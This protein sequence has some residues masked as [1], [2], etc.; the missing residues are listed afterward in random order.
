[1]PTIAEAESQIRATDAPVLFLDTCIY[2]DVIRA[3]DR[4][5]NGFVRSGRD[6]LDLLTADPPRCTL[7]ATSMIPTEW[8][9]NAQKVRDDVL[10]NLVK[11][12]NQAALFHEACDI[13]GIALAFGRPG[14]SGVGLVE[15]LYDLTKELLSLSKV[16]E[17][18]GGCNSRGLRRVRIKTPPSKK[19]G[20]AKDC[21]ILEE[22]LELTRQLRANAYVGKCIFC[23]SNSRDYGEQ[24]ADLHPILANEFATMDL[25][26]ATNLPWAVRD[27]TH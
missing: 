19:G 20:E 6:L 23:S 7:V 27:L 10:G 3:T 1:M 15:R 8:S 24:G 16:L 9:D 25:Q 12:Q 14:Y 26:F 11:S 17:E 18:D 22:C 13:L 21:V 2:L 5:L 4:C